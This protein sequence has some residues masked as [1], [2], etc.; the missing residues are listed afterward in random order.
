MNRAMQKL[1]P[2]LTLFALFSAPP[3]ASATYD[4]GVQRWINRDPV[5]ERGHELLHRAF[6]AN[7][8]TS[9]LYSYEENSPCSNVDPWGLALLPNTSMYNCCQNCL[10]ERRGAPGIGMAVGDHLIWHAVGI[11]GTGAC[12]VLAVGEGFANLTADVGTVV[13][14]VFEIWGVAVTAAEAEELRDKAS[15][16][17]AV[18][19]RNCARQWHDY[20]TAYGTGTSTSEIPARRRWLLPTAK[21]ALLSVTLVGF[22]VGSGSWSST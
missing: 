14:G 6:S 12:G 15:K 10:T 13:F 22:R 5:Q 3:L 17:F 2:I 4:P 1:I 16:A 19:L 11:I 8:Q 20:D 21:D 18:C 7:H 9:N